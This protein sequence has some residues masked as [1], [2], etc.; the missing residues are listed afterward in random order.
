VAALAATLAL[1]LALSG[2]RR[3]SL[4]WLVPPSRAIAPEV[5]PA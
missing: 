2:T 3:F 4:A 1:G 5:P